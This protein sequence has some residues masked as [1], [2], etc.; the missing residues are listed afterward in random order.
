MKTDM[1]DT[2]TTE[3]SHPYARKL[4]RVLVGCHIECEPPRN[5]TRFCPSVESEAKSL[6]AWAR[7]VTEF[8]RD[9][10]SMDPMDIHVVREYQD[11]CSLCECEWETMEEDGATFCA[12][13]GI[14]V[15]PQPERS[16][17]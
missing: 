12:H 10:R 16:A 14:E 8:I 15:E 4:P 17:E 13:C 11:K 3:A 2:Q 6:E 5:V 7:E 1:N 9:H